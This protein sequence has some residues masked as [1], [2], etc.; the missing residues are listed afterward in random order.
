MKIPILMYHSIEENHNELSISL[1][2]F[3]EQ[4]KF[5]KKNNFETISFENLDYKNDKKKFIITFDDGYENVFYNALPILKKYNYNAVCFIVT[6]YIGKYNVWDE[7]KNNF[8]KQSLMNINQIK[9]WLKN[10]MSIGSHTMSHAN[11]KN[12][13]LI[14]KEKEISESWKHLSKLFETNID[15]FSYPYGSYDY[16]AENLAQENYKYSVTTDRSRYV[17]NKFSN[18]S[19]PRIPINKK[20][21]MFKFFIKINTFY[22]DIKF[23]RK[24]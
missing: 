21:G 11:L 19:L 20:D 7:G 3:D 8:L 24:I 9:E 10:G 13:K 14:D 16:D 2:K 17:E 18:S 12:L 23:K 1:K 5:M 4:M 22:E 15:Y 6:N